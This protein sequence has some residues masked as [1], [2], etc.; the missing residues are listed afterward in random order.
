MLKHRLML[1]ILAL[2]AAGCSP[3]P[4]ARKDGPPAPPPPPVA[5]EKKPEPPPPPV[6][7]K[8]EPDPYEKLVAEVGGVVDRYKTI[9]AGIRDQTTAEKGAEQVGQL[10]AKLRGLTEEVGQMPYEPKQD[11]HMQA[12]QVRLAAMNPQQSANPDIQRVLGDPDMATLLLPPSLE[13]FLGMQ[14]F[15]Q[16]NAARRLPMETIAP[17][18]SA[19]PAAAPAPVPALPPSG[20]K[21]P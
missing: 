13:L 6:E 10:S 5:M 4:S 1:T 17:Q 9:L 3:Q 16:A 20:G 7:K 8:A 18:A 12:L 11:K 2:G 19:Q 14:A 21:A 15:L